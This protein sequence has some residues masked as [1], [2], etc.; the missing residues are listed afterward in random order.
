MTWKQTLDYLYSALPM[1]QR[2][3]AAAYKANLDNTHAICKLLGEPQQAFKSIHIAG[4]NGKGSTSHALAAVFIQ[5]GYK[6]GLYTSPHLRDFRERI[7]VNGKMIS[8]QAVMAF[9]GK[10]RQAFETIRPSFFEMTVGLAFDYFRNRQVDIA[11]IETGLGGRLDST[12]VIRPELSIITNTAWDHMNLLG[13]TLEQIATEKAGIIKAGIPV[14]IGESSAPLVNAVRE[15]GRIT[16]SPVYYAGKIYS[17]RNVRQPDVTHLEMDISRSGKPYM[18][19]L[20]L[21]LPGLYQVRN[22]KGVFMALEL[23]RQAGFALPMSAVRGALGRITALTG[24]KG[25]WQ[26]LSKKPLTICDT[27]HNP[28]GIS[29][30]ISQL[31]KIPHQKL[32]MVFGMVSDKDVSAILKL[33]PRK[34]A[35]YFCQASIPR[36]LDAYELAGQAAQFK[37]EGTVIPSVRKA[38]ADARKKAGK[39]DII[40]VGGSTF[41][42]AEVC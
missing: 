5:A 1:Y 31:K 9:T 11:I 37:L 12:N 20:K 34:A 26:V 40:F 7:R 33:L 42:A 3:G 28:A 39:D 32:H 6:T 24:L 23:A 41:V 19:H 36:A 25:R 38:L 21:D 10:Y 4:T 8:R 16:G 15:K 35:Y 22:I 14:I 18:K 17:V 13:H 27:G 30:V 2:L 29:L